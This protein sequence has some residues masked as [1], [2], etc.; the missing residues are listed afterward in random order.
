MKNKILFFVILSIFLSTGI[1]SAQKKEKKIAISG[2]VTDA[3]KK[4]IVNGFIMM[5]GVKTSVVTDANGTY[6]LKV[7]PGTKR[8]GV[9]AFG[10]GLIEEDINGRTIVDF[11]Y[12]TF[13]AGT[14]ADQ[15]V[16]AGEEYVNTGYNYSKKKDVTTSVSTKDES[17]RKYAS[18]ANV[19]EIIGE[20]NGVRITSSGYVIQESKNLWGY[21]PAL[22]VLNGVYVDSFD[23]VSPANI[24]SIEVL[25]GA[26]AAIYGTQ[27][28]GGA[29]VI[30]TRNRD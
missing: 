13:T 2:K 14:T 6:R 10:H 28:Y 11:Q 19:N 21:V 5:D 8:I 23:S 16:P 22:L 15:E 30:K 20:I 3:E 29:I 12:K 27:G 17:A 7:K 25:K 1:V 4:P 26:A 18:Y 24:E 9:V